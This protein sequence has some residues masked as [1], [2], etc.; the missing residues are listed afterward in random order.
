MFPCIMCFNVE[1][2]YGKCP[3]VFEIQNMFK[4]KLVNS[5]ATTTLKPPKPNNVP[6][7]VVVVVTTRSQQPKQ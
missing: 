1:H 3:N 4:I 5:N 6:I 2:K 7:N